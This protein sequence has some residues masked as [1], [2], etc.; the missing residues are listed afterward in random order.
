MPGRAYSKP[1]RI[2][3]KVLEIMAA[4][5][6]IAR[7]R[8]TGAGFT[9][10]SWTWE[11]ADRWVGPAGIEPIPAGE[12]TARL[13]TRHLAAF[14]PATVTDIAWWSG[15]PKTTIRSALVSAGAVEVAL[16]G[17]GEPGYVAGD[18]DLD[19]WDASGVVSLLPGLDATTM[20]WKQRSWY[21]DDRPAAGLFD[22]NGNAGPTIWID[23]RVVGAWTQRPDGEIATMLTDDIGSAAMTAVDREAERLCGWLG[24]SRVRW[25]YPTP[26]TR[27]LDG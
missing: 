5:G 7:G 9:S 26:S 10:G 18:D 19:V 15:L 1:M 13:V 6:R 11:P 21:V 8:P 17:V 3:S 25:R 24:P 22:R 14:G 16:V 20:G 27:R 12:A 4:E 23:G 2:T